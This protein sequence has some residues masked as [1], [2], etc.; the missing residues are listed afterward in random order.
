MVCDCAPPSVQDANVFW[1][2]PDVREETLTLCWP[3]TNA[4]VN[5]PFCVAPSTVTG[6]PAGLVWNV[7]GT[8]P[9]KM[10]VTVCGPFIVTVVEGLDAEATAPDQPEN[11]D[12]EVGLAE[13]G[14]ELPGA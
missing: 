1:T 3:G 14:T 9:L 2:P 10:A 11:T 13:I 5:P 8:S 6:S 7:T 12:P 4:R